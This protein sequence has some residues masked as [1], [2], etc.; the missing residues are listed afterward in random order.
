MVFRRL[1]DGGLFVCHPPQHYE[2]G[3]QDKSYHANGDVEN[4]MT[5]RLEFRPI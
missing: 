2:Q 5:V 4:E 3:N 1:P